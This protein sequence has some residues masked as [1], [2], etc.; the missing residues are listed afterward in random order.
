MAANRLD[1]QLPRIESMIHQRLTLLTAALTDQ[2][3][4]DCG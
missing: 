3:T 2:R 1:L 4:D